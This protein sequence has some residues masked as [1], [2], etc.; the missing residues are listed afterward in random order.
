MYIIKYKFHKSI[1]CVLTLFA[2]IHFICGCDYIKTNHL[3]L[4]GCQTKTILKGKDKVNIS[5]DW[6]GSDTT[7]IINIH[8][9]A[10]GNNWQIRPDSLFLLPS[11]RDIAVSLYDQSK[12]RSMNVHT[13]YSLIGKKELHNNQHFTIIH[14]SNIDKRSISFYLLPSALITY[15]GYPVLSDTITISFPVGDSIQSARPSAK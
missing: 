6:T 15:Y 14:N 7:Y 5:C 4:D 9:D 13:A 2:G 1:L 11:S 12:T 10:F 8:I 3:L